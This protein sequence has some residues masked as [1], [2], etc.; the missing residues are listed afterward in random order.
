MT[1]GAVTTTDQVARSFTGARKERVGE[2]LET[3]VSLG[4]AREVEAGRY[5]V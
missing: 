1:S 5:L 4:Q 2:I 3:L